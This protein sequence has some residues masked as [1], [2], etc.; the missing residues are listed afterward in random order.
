[1]VT[2]KNRGGASES[3]IKRFSVILEKIIIN[4][5]IPSPYIIKLDKRERESI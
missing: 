2:L 5:T 3:M 1:M 4:K